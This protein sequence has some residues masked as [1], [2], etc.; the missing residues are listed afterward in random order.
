MNA[1]GCELFHVTPASL[2]SGL[3]PSENNEEA[4]CVLPGLGGDV[5]PN[6]IGGDVMHRPARRNVVGD[7]ADDDRQLTRRSLV[8][9]GRLTSDSSFRARRAASPP[10]GLQ[11]QPHG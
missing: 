1:Y 5:E 7:L 4:V 10:G 11:I 6:G 2:R 9:R 8:R 3:A